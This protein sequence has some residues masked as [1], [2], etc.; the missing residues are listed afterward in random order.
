MNPAGPAGDGI[1]L[2][3]AALRAD[4]ADIASYTTVLTSTLGDVLPAGMVS[5]DRDRTLLD[6]LTGRPGRP[7]VLRVR[8]PG[9][10]LR[11]NQDPDGLTAEV[12]TIVRNV[13][14]A[15]RPISV[16][17]WV[18]AL[19][20]ELTTLAA[21]DAATSAALARFLAHPISRGRDAR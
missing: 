2:V 6:R 21:R 16:S 15:R 4:R 11:L 3:A 20:T 10:E 9:G 1:A 17:E 14:I 5:I 7:S 13:V 18:H 8:L 19:A 12:Y